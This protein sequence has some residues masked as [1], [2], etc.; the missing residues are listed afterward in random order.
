MQSCR[1]ALELNWHRNL[2]CTP[3]Y[4]G[5]E[6]IT[7]GQ[8]TQTVRK[9]FE[10]G[11]E[12]KLV[13]WCVYNCGN[14]L[15]SQTPRN[16]RCRMLLCL[17]SVS[18]S[19]GLQTLRNTE[20]TRYFA[21]LSL[22]QREFACTWEMETSVSSGATPPEPLPQLCSFWSWASY[23]PFWTYISFFMGR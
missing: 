8:N 10:S 4:H 13:S 18:Q 1:P 2:I 15:N 5:A 11:E 23:W 7:S 22:G 21:V 17:L 20:V 14:T 19:S 9:A 16:Q 3:L 6:L 12:R